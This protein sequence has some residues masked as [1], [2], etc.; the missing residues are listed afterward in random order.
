MKLSHYPSTLTDNSELQGIS[1]KKRKKEKTHA[2][3]SSKWTLESFML[4]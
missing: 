4:T 3:E 1:K 2:E